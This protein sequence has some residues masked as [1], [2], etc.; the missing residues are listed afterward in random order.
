MSDVTAAIQL[1]GGGRANARFR[2]VL[3]AVVPEGVALDDEQWR[4]AQ[5]IMGRA[6]S[7]RPASV[8]RQI[9]LFLRVLDV[10]SFVRHGRPLSALPPGEATG[11][12]ETLS[13]SR[14]LLMRRG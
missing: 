2:A 8:R 5:L 14:L 11:I 12:L 7:A 6:L 4:E 3:N 1:P 13:R 9:G 10:V